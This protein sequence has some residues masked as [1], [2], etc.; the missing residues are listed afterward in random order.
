MATGSTPSKAIGCA[1]VVLL[2]AW[3][4]ADVRTRSLVDN[5]LLLIAATIAI[6]LPVGTVLAVAL[7]RTDVAGRRIA[8]AALGVLLWIPLYL[9]AAAWQAGFGVTG[10]FTALTAAP[11]QAGLL[12]GWR[13]AIWVHAMAA[14]PW[15]AL[16]VGA[17]LR[18][19]PELEEAALLDGSPLQVLVSVTLRHARPAI[20]LAAA[21]TAISVAIDMTVADLFGIRTYAEEIYTEFGLGTETGPPVGIG[22]GIA[23][24]SCLAA[25]AVWLCVAAASWPARSSAR[26]PLIFRLGKFRGAASAAIVAVVGLMAAVPLASLIYKA[27]VVVVPAATYP[28]REWS[29]AKFGEIL[30][31]SGGRYSGEIRWSIGTAAIAASMA[32][33]LAIPL[34]WLERRRGAAAL[35]ALGVSVAALAVPGPLVGLGLIAIFNAPGMTALNYLYDHTVIVTAIAQAVRAFPIGMLIVWHALG[36][37]S[38]DLLEAAA[39]D[40]ATS[41]QRLRRVVLP[42]RW[43]A[44]GLAWLAAFLVAIG[45]LSATILVAP[46][47]VWTLGTRVAHLLHFNMQNELAGLCLFLLSAAILLGTAVEM[48]ARSRRTILRR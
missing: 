40:G 16:I 8:I 3:L 24:T 38:P 10:W 9:Q 19:E 48:A 12:D 26:P 29:L 23:V 27:G 20:G 18:S 13:G 44:I 2:G 21:W 22:L 7:C 5:T 41:W 6:S 45:E 25:C 42:S 30:A 14:I 33:G 37:I 1:V 35:P 32:I 36:T 15:V 4:C 28:V 46:P 47:G 11:Y 39:A 43:P 31:S 17:S 34:A